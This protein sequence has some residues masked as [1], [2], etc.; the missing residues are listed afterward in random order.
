MSELRGTIHGYSTTIVTSSNQQ[1]N[2]LNAWY[3]LLPVWLLSC[4]FKGK[5][6]LFGDER[7][8]R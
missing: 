7:A 6:Y 8:H 2:D 4:E 1:F 3:T 5:P